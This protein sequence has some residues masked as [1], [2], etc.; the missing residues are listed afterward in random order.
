MDAGYLLLEMLSRSLMFVLVF[1]LYSL[2]GLWMARISYV[3][4][5]DYII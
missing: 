2:R 1:V 4:H 5:S 3:G